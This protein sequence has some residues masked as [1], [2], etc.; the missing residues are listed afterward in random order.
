MPINDV[1]SE[2]FISCVLGDQEF[3]NFMG[4]AELGGPASMLNFATQSPS[5]DVL[6][7]DNL[8]SPGVT[9]GYNCDFTATVVS[10]SEL[11][12]GVDC[13]VF[14]ADANYVDFGYMTTP[15]LFPPP[16]ISL[17]ISPYGGSTSLGVGKI[18]LV[19]KQT[20][21]PLPIFGTAIAFGFARRL[22]ART[23]SA[24]S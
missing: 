18:E 23:H 14:T 7:I 13:A 3:S 1:I 8:I 22:R 24:R 9:G 17:V 2:A 6:T 15:E 20:P 4:L 5:E 11:I 12:N 16:T 21:G 19:V 10:G